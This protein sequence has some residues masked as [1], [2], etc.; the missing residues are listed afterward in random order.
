MHPLAANR[1]RLQNV[2]NP[3]QGDAKR[4]LC[5]CSA[6]LLR[7]PTLA[8]ILQ[9]KPYNFNC[10]AAGVDASHALIPVDQALLEWAEIVICV[11]KWSALSTKH[12]I[13]EFNTDNIL[14]QLEIP[15]QYERNSPKLIKEIKK[16]LKNLTIPE[17]CS[18]LAAQLN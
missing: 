13:A 17:T 3:Y 6:G 11:D 12:L 10:R 4:L 14:I 9:N 18:K 7:S 8:H 15:D 2:N 1:N 5:V 16:Q